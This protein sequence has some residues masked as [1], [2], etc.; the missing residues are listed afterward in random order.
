[1]P[2]GLIDKLALIAIRDEK[3]L[4]TRERGKPVWFFP[5][6]RREPGETD[7][8]ALL[9]EVRE[10]LALTLDPK[11]LKFY[12]VFEAPAYGHSDGTVVRLTCYLG[13]PTGEPTPG[14][15]VES[16]AF[17]SSADRDRL[18]GAGLLV[19]D[20]LRRREWIS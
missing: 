1:M 19:F 6:G 12:G 18:T 5:G 3:V 11:D 14:A 17:L 16:C 10:E 4:M 7:H 2:A 8:E 15:E 9:R 13:H 20:D